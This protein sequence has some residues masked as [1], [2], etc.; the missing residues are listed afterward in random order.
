M[1]LSK[2][3]EPDKLSQG[4]LSSACCLNS[5]NGFSFGYLYAF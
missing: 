4:Q 5:L 1:D 2:S 3:H